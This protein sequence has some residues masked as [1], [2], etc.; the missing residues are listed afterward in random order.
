MTL[1][2][3]TSPDLI[4][5]TL[6]ATHPEEAI[7]EL[8]EVLGAHGKVPDVGTFQQNV[9]QHEKKLCGANVLC[10]LAFPH[11][12]MEG[13]EALSFA[14]GGSARGITWFGGRQA[15]LIF[16]FGIPAVDGGAY[17]QV[18][19]TLARL[20]RDT[21]S[22]QRL[23]VSATSHETAAVLDTFAVRLPGEPAGPSV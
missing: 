10:P 21:L 9:I 2:R 13:I 3:F 20:S 8:A 4:V 6:R 23:L 17:L 15:R 22:V 14:V 1:A 11:G 5:P 18:V 12:R 7:E 16:L 19:S